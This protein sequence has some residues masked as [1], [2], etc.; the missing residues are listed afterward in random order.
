MKM[1][2]AL[3]SNFEVHDVEKGMIHNE[4]KKIEVWMLL[5]NVGKSTGTTH[6]FGRPTNHPT[7]IVC[8]SQSTPSHVSISTAE[9]E[10]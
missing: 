4:M 8:D 9:R 2:M 10:A 6:E 5:A 7:V 1:L 3:N